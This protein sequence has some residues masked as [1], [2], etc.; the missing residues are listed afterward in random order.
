MLVPEFIRVSIGTAV[1]LGLENMQLD[2]KPTTAY[3]MLYTEKRCIANC[4][5]CPQARES[6]ARN[7]LLS[8]IYWPKFELSDVKKAFETPSQPKKFK[9][10][11]VQAINY[12]GFFDDLVGIVKS[13]VDT[14]IP[15]SISVQ[16]LT[17]KQITELHEL[18][19]SRIGIP[20]DAATETIF[21]NVKGKG[22]KSPYKW[23]NYVENIKIAQ[24]VFGIDNV[25]THLVIG[26]G[27]TEL[28]A[29]NFIQESVDIGVLPALFTFTPIKGTKLEAKSRPTLFKYRKIQLA[30]YLIFERIS[31][32]E[33]FSFNTT[34]EI[35]NFGI[36]KEE[37]LEII[38]IGK[39]FLTSG[40]SG[41]NRP[42]Y[43]ERPGEILYNYPRPLNDD[44][45][46]QIIQL[47]E[48]RMEW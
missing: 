25:S 35:I 15:I 46:T 16:P 3:L 19:V 36:P 10:I 1:I 30:R 42:Y 18:G 40:C 28:E 17:K 6:K 27:E 9:R 23:E 12:E 48:E 43:N 34:E 44:E 24:S 13:L 38:R 32:K 20:F 33:N 37:L 47:F 31:R 7:D 29:V 22:I 21:Y 41:C 4:G 11:C 2:A 8:R 45:I 39:P 14:K 5:F 26:L